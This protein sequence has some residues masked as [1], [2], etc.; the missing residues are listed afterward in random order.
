MKEL[1]TRRTTERVRIGN[2]P[3]KVA[4]ACVLLDHR[5]T[6][7]LSTLSKVVHRRIDFFPGSAKMDLNR[8]L[9]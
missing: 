5:S 7:H 4:R 6:Q 3:L 2:S 9:N 8:L 1:E